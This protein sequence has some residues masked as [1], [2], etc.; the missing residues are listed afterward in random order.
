MKLTTADL[1]TRVDQIQA[2]VEKA[3]HRRQDLTQELA[4]LNSAIDQ[5]TG[6][7]ALLEELLA[8]DGAEAADLVPETA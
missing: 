4:R 2:N 5:G 8:T 7:L 3:R 1:M 6:A